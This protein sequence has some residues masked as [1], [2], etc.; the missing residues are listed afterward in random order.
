MG[1]LAA[2]MTTGMLAFGFVPAQAAAVAKVELQA[3]LT[4]SH[5][6]SHAVGSAKFE[7]GRHGRELIVSV[8]H[9]ARLAGRSLVVF[10]HGARAGT[11]TVSRTGFA[12]MDRHGVPACQAGQA[13]RVRTK[14][15]TLV[16]SGTFRRHH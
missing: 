8:S 15:G 11:M 6:F 14:A 7:S 13:I 4:G 9:V 12:H 16:V 3:A 5:A 1:G 2:V 10:V